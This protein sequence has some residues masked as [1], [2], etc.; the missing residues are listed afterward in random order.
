MEDR[1]IAYKLV[2]AKVLGST[3]QGHLNL[4]MESRIGTFSP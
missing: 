2:F 4:A 1:G 3:L